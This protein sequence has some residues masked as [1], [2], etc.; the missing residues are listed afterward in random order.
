[1]KFSTKLQVALCHLR[2]CLSDAGCWAL[3]S[4]FLVL[5]FKEERATVLTPL[6]HP[7]VTSLLL[8]VSPDD[9][10]CLSPRHLNIAL[11][12]AAYMPLGPLGLPWCDQGLLQ[13]CLT[14]TWLITSCLDRPHDITGRTINVFDLTATQSVSK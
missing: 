9:P 2:P 7:M 10:S 8:L 14:P 4:S 12:L 6:A 1:M 11:C 3:S 5:F 13:V